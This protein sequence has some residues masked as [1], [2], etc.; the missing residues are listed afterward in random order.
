MNRRKATAFAAIAVV[1]AAV[2]I[3]RSPTKAR[4]TESASWDPKRPKK[5]SPETALAIGLKTAEVDFGQ[6]EEV[7]NSPAPCAA[8][9][10]ARRRVTAR[11]A[12]C[13]RSECSR[14]TP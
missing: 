8:T 2:L 9:I 14:A 1:T 10:S 13:E 7:M 3:R 12:S 11:R 5:V 4:Q 6:V